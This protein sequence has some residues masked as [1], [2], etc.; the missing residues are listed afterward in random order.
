MWWW[1]LWTSGEPKDLEQDE[2]SLCS[3]SD[4]F[5]IFLGRKDRGLT[6][7]KYNVGD[8]CCRF[9]GL[10]DVPVHL[11]L[12]IW[13]KKIDYPLYVVNVLFYFDHEARQQHSWKI[14]NCWNV[15]NVKKK[16]HEAITET[17]S[18][19]TSYVFKQRSQSSVMN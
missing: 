19:N 15:G 9:Y 16:E 11:S 12:R 18:R 1:S 4:I 6:R 10:L 5:H 2:N 14:G 8:K 13:N 17:V 7:L 3:S